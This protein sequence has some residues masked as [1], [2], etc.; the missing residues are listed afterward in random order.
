MTFGEPTNSLLVVIRYE[1]GEEECSGSWMVYNS[2]LNDMLSGEFWLS[3]IV[4]NDMHVH[5]AR[6]YKRKPVDF[7]KRVGEG[8]FLEV[9]VIHLSLQVGKEEL[10]VITKKGVRA[11]HCNMLTFSFLQLQSSRYEKRS[12]YKSYSS[13]Y[14]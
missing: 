14:L 7:L 3:P 10:Y 4:G 12:I 6:G 9:G 2:Q 5:S 13:T 11:P 1:R 8:S